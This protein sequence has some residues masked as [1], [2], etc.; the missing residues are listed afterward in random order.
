MRYRLDILVVGRS[1]EQL[2]LLRD[3]L[4]RQGD[5][6]VS[7]RHVSN[8]HTDPL[9]NVKPLPD[10]LV[11][12]LS[13]NWQAEL[14]ALMER[15]AS[16]RPPLLV[17]GPS[18][19]VD[20]I[21]EAMR[22]GARDYF[23]PPIA[24]DELAQSL[25][26]I[27]R[28]K[29]A[30]I[31]RHTAHLTA[32]INAKGGSGAS[33]VAA[34]LA[35][36]LAATSER[37]TVLMDMDLQFGA[38]PL[39]FNLAPRNGMVRALELVDSLDAVALEGYVQT[40]QSG[41]SLLASAPDELVSIAEV[42]ESRVELLLQVM[43]GVY[44]DIVVD[45]P[46]VLGG[47]TAMVLERADRILVVLE[48]SVAHLRDAKRLIGILKQEIHVGDP[49]ITVVVN[50]Y[51]KSSEVS[52]QDIRDALPG[53]QIV[54]LPNDFRNVAQSINV[55]S[56]LLESA[57][58]APVTRDLLNLSRGLHEDTQHEGRRKGAWS[59]FGWGRQA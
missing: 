29:S 42:P 50:R 7:V 51:N 28:D 32:V 57:P 58:R 23:T 47:A 41:L 11:L 31:A 35:H 1:R 37:R 14:S 27:M 44:D 26:Q 40:H 22:A 19:N 59:L 45:L 38:L 49:R 18:G 8:G 36:V 21:R 53:Q 24:E 6:N 33:M 55:G 10:A 5:V 13:E 20:V 15:P 43:S 3:L 30:E 12:V 46:R 48:Q 54:T 25:Q 39:Y 56:P 4:G 2:D 16:E 9:Y 52:L 34:N 17:I